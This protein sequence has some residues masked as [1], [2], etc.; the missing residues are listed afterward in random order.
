ME[1]R[2]A[3]RRENSYRFDLVREVVDVDRDNQKVTYHVKPDPRRYKWITRDDG[4]YLFD[5]LD[6]AL[7]PKALVF[8]MIREALSKPTTEKPQAVGNTFEF[9]E[10]RKPI[11]ETFIANQKVP[12]D[13]VDKS[14]DFLESLSSDKLNFVILSIDLVGSTSLATTVDKNQYATTIALFAHEMAYIVSRFH[15][16]VLK[17]TG[18]GL[19]AYFPEPSF[20]AMNDLAIDCALTMRS[21]VYQVINPAFKQHDMPP[22]DVRIGLD[23]GEAA[24]IDIGHPEAKQHKDIIGIVLNLATEIQSCA[25]PGDVCFGEVVHR[26]LHGFWREQCELAPTPPDWKHEIRSGAPYTLYR[27]KRDESKSY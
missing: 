25:R 12:F 13:S 22:L 11:V 26:H 8:E 17:F 14:E 1:T 9:L 18:D 6:R 23:A 5:T 20:I 10:S 19:L 16:H 2:G 4:E 3:D 21:C 7:F 24:I 15:G 27:V